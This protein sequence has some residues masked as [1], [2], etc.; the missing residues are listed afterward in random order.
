M[1]SHTAQTVLDECYLETRAKLLEV[2]AVLDRVDRAGA[3]K[4]PLTGDAAAKRE[5]IAEA[6]QILLLDTPTR[7]ESI[8]QLFSRPF[9]PQWRSNF[10]LQVEHASPSNTRES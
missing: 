10:G 1:K 2:A 6:I 4:S 7:A 8:Q 3:T 9:D 5:Q